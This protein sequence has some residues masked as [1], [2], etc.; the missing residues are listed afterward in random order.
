[1][2]VFARDRVTIAI[3]VKDAALLIRGRKPSSAHGYK[4]TSGSDCDRIR[5]EMHE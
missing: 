2:A 3:R 5:P 4:S 1:M